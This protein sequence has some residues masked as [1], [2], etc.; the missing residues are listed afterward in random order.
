MGLIFFFLPFICAILATIWP[1]K[2]AL[3]VCNSALSN[4]V[5]GQ[6]GSSC[7]QN[8]GLYL[9]TTTYFGHLYSTFPIWVVHKLRI[10]DG[11]GRWSKNLHFLSTFIP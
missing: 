5:G 8:F 10:Q 4:T 2:E 6:L 9:A 7:V 3:F 11:V 1:H